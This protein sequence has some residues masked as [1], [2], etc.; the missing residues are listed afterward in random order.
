M[1]HM[2]KSMFI[3][4]LAMVV[5]LVVALSTATF[6]WYTANTTVQATTTA[7]QS[8]SSDSA[9]IAVETSEITSGSTG[10]SVTMTLTGAI[11][12]MIL[13]TDIS[14][15]ENSETLPVFTTAPVNNTNQFTTAGT[16]G[17]P[18]TIATVQDNND[19]NANSTLH[20]FYV[21]N[22]NKDT[23]PEVKVTV[24]INSEGYIVSTPS[25]TYF[26]AHKT[27]FYTTADNIVFTACTNESVFN[28]QTTYYQ[29]NANIA[30]YLRIAIYSNGKYIGTWA[31]TNTA[32]SYGTIVANTIGTVED[33]AN[34][35]SFN[36]IASGT[37]SSNRI[38]LTGVDSELITL[39][40]WFDGCLLTATESNAYCSFNIT[41]DK[42][43]APAQNP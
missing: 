20:G 23:D 30:T 9:A 21:G 41:F 10:T 1:K 25:E 18:A 13:T 14:D 27:D 3:T 37:A 32:V 22:T 33:N 29:S 5:V 42:Y 40:A 17:T 28:G 16:S 39:Y 36:A 35:N 2:K 15:A 26:N 7:A 19:V 24:T 31:R 8:A 34:I 12:P 43:T 38:A 6:A 11:A 4:T